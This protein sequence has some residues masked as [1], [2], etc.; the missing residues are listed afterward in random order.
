MNILMESTWW[1]SERLLLTLFDFIL[2]LLLYR[3][4]LMGKKKT[5]LE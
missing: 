3:E 5:N 4:E 1:I 2:G